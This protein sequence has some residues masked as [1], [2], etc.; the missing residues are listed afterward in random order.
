[1]L[2]EPLD[3]FG[4]E[5]RLFVNDSMSAVWNLYPSAVAHP[6]LEPIEAICKCETF[7]FA[8]DQERWS[9]HILP[10][11]IVMQI[12]NW[13]CHD[14]PKYILWVQAV[15]KAFAGRVPVWVCPGVE[16]GLPISCTEVLQQACRTVV[17]D[18]A[19]NRAWLCPCLVVGGAIGLGK[20]AGRNF[21]SVPEY[22]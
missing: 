19:R 5:L 10:R 16:K 11:Y 18:P 14:R 4:N 8:D 7:F 6:T 3:V 15:E 12:I 9:K 17:I 22:P 21:G 2:D 1:M 13:W 20:V